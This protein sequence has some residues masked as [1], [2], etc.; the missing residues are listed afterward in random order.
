MLEM[1][2]MKPDKQLDKQRYIQ[3][4]EDVCKTKQMV[5]V[6]LEI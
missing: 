5:S 3:L 2:K 1:K 6:I 4:K